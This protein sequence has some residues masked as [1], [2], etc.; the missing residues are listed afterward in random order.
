MEIR[1]IYTHRLHNRRNLLIAII[2]S[3]T[4]CIAAFLF[5]PKSSGIA[6]TI[7]YTEP[8]ILINNIQ[9]TTQ[10]PKM[11]KIKPTAPVIVIVDET[12][13]TEILDDVIVA[14]IFSKEEDSDAQEDISELES[15]NISTAPRLTF[16]VL[17]EEK[18]DKIS[19]SLNLFLKIDTT[20][21]VISHKVLFSSIECG[22]CMDKIINA[23]YRSKWQPALS[24]GIEVDYL[25]EKSYV[26]N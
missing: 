8:I 9:P 12:E 20:G 2:I 1:L 21:K 11:E 24:H 7:K 10:L 3:E 4:L 14:S 16:E 5:S 13:E 18:D 23:V 25:V 22:N 26:F 15:G 17:P 19:G 6:S